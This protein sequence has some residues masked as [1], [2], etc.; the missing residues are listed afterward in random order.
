M[1]PYDVIDKSI[2]KMM[3]DGKIDASDIPEMVMLITTLS[4]NTFIPKNT[5]D[6]GKSIDEL[7]AFIMN[8]YDLFPKT[9]EERAVFD[10][11]FQSCLRLVLYQ[12]LVK[13]KCDKFWSLGCK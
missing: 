13:S 7:Y 8:K 6:L 10:K 1:N 3:S 4:A 5:D 2:K 12:P 11:L 9:G